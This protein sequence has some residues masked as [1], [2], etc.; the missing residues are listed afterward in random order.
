M[1]EEKKKKGG[2]LKEVSRR[3]FMVKGGKY[4]LVTGAAMQVLFTSKRA[5]A[6]SGLALFEVGVEGSAPAG[7]FSGPSSTSPS[8]SWQGS[9]HHVQ[10]ERYTIHFTG[11]TGHLPNTFPVTVSLAPNGLEQSGNHFYWY[12]NVSTGS[13]TFTNV[14]KTGGSLGVN[15]TIF[16]SGGSTHY[17]PE[18]L[19]NSNSQLTGTV[20][21]TAS[22]VMPLTISVVMPGNNP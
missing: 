11:D 9:T 15:G 6:Q 5:M 20:T 16:D 14:P 18:V 2:I 7:T 8:G 17:L 1:G 3:D 21:F 19:N 13:Y 4:A 22:G 10:Y 12:S